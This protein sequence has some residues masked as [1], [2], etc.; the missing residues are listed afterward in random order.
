MTRDQR[1]ALKL[2]L[3]CMKKANQDLAVDANIAHL[4]PNTV[5]P[6][7]QRRADRYAELSRAMNTIEEMMM[8]KGL[9]L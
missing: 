5:S 9:G 6:T 2:A 8:Q 7:I 1:K 3:E 4:N